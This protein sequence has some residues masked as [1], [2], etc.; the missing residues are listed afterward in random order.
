MSK[1]TLGLVIG[2]YFLLAFAFEIYLQLRR[3]FESLN[4]ISVARAFG[5]SISLFVISAI[6]PLI[7]WAVSKFRMDRAKPSFIM[8]VLCGLAYGFFQ[9][10][11]SR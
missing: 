2:A 9:S 6:I 8:W 5:G 1:R 10:L 3:P 7:M 4:P 11:G